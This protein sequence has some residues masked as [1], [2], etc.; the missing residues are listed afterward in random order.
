M[1]N[2]HSPDA[3]RKGE[4]NPVSLRPAHFPDPEEAEKDAASRGAIVRKLEETLDQKGA[5]ALVGNKGYARFLK[6]SKGG[7]TINQE[8]VEADRRFDGKFVLRT[9]TE[10]PAAEV[11]QTFVVAAHPLGAFHSSVCARLAPGAFY[12]II[13]LDSA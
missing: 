2:D 11:A 10:L 5:K 4:E 7:M 3:R 8:A 6:V 1:E 13:K 12:E 9:N